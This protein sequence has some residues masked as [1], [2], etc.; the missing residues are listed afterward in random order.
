MGYIAHF[1]LGFS[2][3]KSHLVDP[4][5]VSHFSFSGNLAEHG[6]LWN[7]SVQNTDHSDKK[8]SVSDSMMHVSHLCVWSLIS[9]IVAHNVTRFPITVSGG[10][11]SLVSS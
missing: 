4:T 11:R 5:C 2:Q 3:Q 8:W 7:R 1:L 10:T 9:I 6:H